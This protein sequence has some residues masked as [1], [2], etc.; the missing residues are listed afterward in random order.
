MPRPST[1]K[2]APPPAA[3]SPKEK[4]KPK[5]GGG[6]K[7][8]NVVPAPEAVGKIVYPTIQ[9]NGI[10]VPRAKLKVTA[11]TFKKFL[12]WE[13]E[14]EY[15]LRR[16]KENPALMANA[17]ALKWDSWLLI[18]ENGDK[19]RCHRNVTNRDFREPDCRAIA[20][21]IL[22][23]Q[24]KLNGETCLVGDR[25]NA[26][27]MQHRGIALILAVQKWLK[28]QNEWKEYWKE[29][30]YIEALIVTGVPEDY[31]TVQTIDTTVPRVLAD[32]YAT[33]GMFD[34][35]TLPNKEDIEVPLDKAKRTE[36]SRLMDTAT[37]LL[38]KRAGAGFDAKVKFQT[39]AMSRDFLNRHPSLVAAGKHLFRL[40]DGR[41]ISMKK[42]LRGQCAAFMYLMGVSATTEEAAKA[43]SKDPH[44]SEEMLDLSMWGKAEEF[45][46]GMADPSDKRE[47]FFDAVTKALF[48]I[49]NGDLGTIALGEKKAAVLVK[50]WRAYVNEESLV[51]EDYMSLY[52][53]TDKNNQ[54][55]IVVTEEDLTFGGIDLGYSP[56]PDDEIS[57]AEAEANA[58]KQ[59]QTIAARRSSGG[60]R[61]TTEVQ[62]PATVTNAVKARLD[63]L[64]AMFPG[65]V[66]F[67]RTMDGGLT[68]W[69]DQAEFVAGLK[70][71]KP[72]KRPDGLLQYKTGGS[73]DEL[74]TLCG[75]IKANG[76]AA[77][78]IE[79]DDGEGQPETSNPMALLEPAEAP[80]KPKKKTGK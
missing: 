1:E 54:G 12:G 66:L 18:D 75:M 10:E 38:W 69:Q 63:T 53:E 33:S 23:R 31:D 58:A 70:G 47:K 43:Y 20:Q 39:H 8:E 34:T 17:E 77:I 37:D 42:L 64:I 48:H 74:K 72:K 4:D 79:K 24:W 67:M 21:S 2:K 22:L 36:A 25:G 76:K 51:A 44:R 57:P 5:K 16:T 14:A 19:V 26:L 78:I 56:E 29:E 55:E 9:V 7:A 13:T 65:K 80:V 3:P 60:G 45:W 61:G 50:A 49:V 52:P 73:V 40:D 41:Q 68:V 62:P 46:Q 27:S 71:A 28:D 15:I 6:K 59:A 35:W 32:A 11:A 30:P